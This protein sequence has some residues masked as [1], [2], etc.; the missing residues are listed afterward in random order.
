VMPK[1]TVMPVKL[2]ITMHQSSHVFL[3]MVQPTGRYC[4]DPGLNSHEGS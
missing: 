3:R 2:A 4:A 1:V